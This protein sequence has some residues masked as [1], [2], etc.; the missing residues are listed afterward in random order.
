[1]KHKIHI[2][3]TLAVV[4][5]ASC[6]LFEKQKLSIKKQLEKEQLQ[7][8][9]QRTTVTE[10]SQL[11]LIDSSQNDYTL[12]LWPK[13]KFTFSPINGFEGEAEKVIIKG[14]EIRKKIVESNHKTRQDSTVL[15]ANY[16]KEK[17]S[18]ITVEKNKLSAGN[19]WGW[20]LVL[21]IIIALIWVYRRFKP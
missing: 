10:Q 7:L 11:I 5:L 9:A 3:I 17:E 13:G 16:A 18:T 2:T 20:V 14:K 1:M 21:L 6:H 8:D 12:M 15:K 4:I 19:N